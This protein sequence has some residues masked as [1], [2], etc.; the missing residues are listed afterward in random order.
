MTD[1]LI[2]LLIRLIFVI[3]VIILTTVCHIDIALRPLNGL[4]EKHRL[5]L[6]GCCLWSNGELLL[7]IPLNDVGRQTR[8]AAAERVCLT[9]TLQAWERVRGARSDDKERLGDWTAGPTVCTYSVHKIIVG[10]L[11]KKLAYNTV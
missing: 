6:L 11:T 2:E 4:I 10:I 5:K 7:T 3:S 9:L 8:L 1:V